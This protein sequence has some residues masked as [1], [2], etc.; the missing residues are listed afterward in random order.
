MWE[1]ESMLDHDQWL[2]KYKRKLI[3]AWKLGFDDKDAAERVGIS[4]EEYQKHLAL[5]EHLRQQRDNYVDELLRIAKDNIA[6][7][8]MA[9]DRQSCEWYIEHK[10]PA[11]GAKQKYEPIELSDEEERRKEIDDALTK[12]MDKFKPKED[13]FDGNK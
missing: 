11:F 1:S 7:K 10:D 2:K 9:G 3:Y 4:Y 13:M 12:F 6:Q 5:D 8:I